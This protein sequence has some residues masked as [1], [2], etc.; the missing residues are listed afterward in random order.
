MSTS[1]AANRE[2]T[3]PAPASGTGSETR[4]TRADIARYRVNRQG[5]I[6]SAALYR[7][8]AQLEADAKLASVYGH[9][10]ETETAHAAFWERLIPESERRRPPRVSWRTRTL[11]ALAKRFGPRVVLPTVLEHERSDSTHYDQQAESRGSSLPADERSHGRLLGAMAATPSGGM[12]GATIARLEGRH[13]SMGG[14]ALRAAVLG[15]NDGLVSNLSLVMGVAG[16]AASDRV[17]LVTGLAGLLAGAGSMAMGEWLSVQSARELHQRQ[18]AIET[19]ELAAA[20]AEETNELALIY[21]AK[22]LTEE[23]ARSLAERLMANPET[24]RETLVREELGIDPAELGGSAWQAAGTSAMLFSVGAIVPVLPFFFLSASAAVIASV[25]GSAVAL[26]L[27]GAG[28]T[29]LTGR[30]V[31]YSGARQLLFGAVAAG[32][33]YGVG[34]LL[35]AKISG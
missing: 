18:I 10:A 17:L 13:R 28:I 30:S 19:A 6:D 21:Q 26:F 8:L 7:A 25:A 12:E 33:T 3:P 16:A 34:S 14:N 9:M 29:L 5:E 24:A 23:Q 32:L 4:L 11:I 20:P 27:I 15:A 31:W 1:N 35:G 22:G 2:T